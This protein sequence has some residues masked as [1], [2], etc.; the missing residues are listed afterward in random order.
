MEKYEVISTLCTGR[1]SRICKIRKKGSS[2]AL[3]WKEINYGKMSD[4]EKQYLVS[5][6][7][8][9]R[10]LR[11]PNIVRYYDRVISK[12]TA[13]IYIIMEYCSKGDLAKEIQ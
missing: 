11:H 2:R 4:K 6:V 7:N 10:E 8:I 5:E 12:K 1:S 13:T 9:L 3:C